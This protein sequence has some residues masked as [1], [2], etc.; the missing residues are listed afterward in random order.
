MG[1]DGDD[2]STGDVAREKTIS[3]ARVRVAVSLPVRVSERATALAI[4]AEA[5]GVA[6]VPVISIIGASGDVVARTPP[7]SAAS[8]TSET[9]CASASTA[10]LVA[11]RPYAC[12]KPRAV[13]ASEPSAGTTTT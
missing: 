3:L 5:R 8:G 1:T 12:A 7:R 9:W 6:A 13:A 4:S 2:G 11:T 10:P